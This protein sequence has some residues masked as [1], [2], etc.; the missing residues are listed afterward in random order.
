MKKL[1][2]RYI[3]FILGI[4]INSFGIVFITKASLGTSP[5][6]SVPYVLSF[7]F[8]LSFGAFTFLL[9]MLF[10]LGEV[11]LL[12]RQFRPYQY[13]QIVVNMIFS[14]FIDISMTLLESFTPTHFASQILSLLVGC[15]ILALGICIEVAPNVLV[16][17]GEGIVKTL[18]AKGGW[19]F[20]NVK[21]AFD[22]TLTAIASVIAFITFGRLNGVGI[23]TLVSA[24]AVG[25]LVK[26]YSRCIKR[27]AARRAGG[28]AVH[29]DALEAA[30]VVAVVLAAGHFTMQTVFHG[31]TSHRIDLQA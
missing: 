17:P 31:G 13:L 19:E 26:L 28:G 7:R 15:T 30:L 14:S 23:G 9:N 25:Q 11:I 29:L 24:L 1:I 4:L 16:V 20:G 27:S 2:S 10:I 22:C 6:S 5:I 18:A 21:V 8:P 3:W 12:R